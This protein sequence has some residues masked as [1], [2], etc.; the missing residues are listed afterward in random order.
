MR[1]KKNIP[2]LSQEDRAFF[3]RFY[4]EYRNFLYYIA[5]QYASSQADCDDLVQ[6]ALI[7]L[8]SNIQTLKTMNHRKTVKYIALTVKS[9]FLDHQRQTGKS[10]ALSLENPILETQ[11]DTISNA[12]DLS[13]RMDIYD[14]KR[15][16]SPRDWL[17]LE[18]KYLLG[19]DQKDIARL[20]KISPDSVRMILHRAKKK[21]RSILLTDD[22][23][24]GECHD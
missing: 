8:L 5:R 9:V 15:S 7:R 24:G 12:S 13:L 1:P 22:G 20:L 2:P 17:V 14:L 23:N 19:Y 16:L 6:T 18:G 4:E 10:I 3:Q 21:A 11:S